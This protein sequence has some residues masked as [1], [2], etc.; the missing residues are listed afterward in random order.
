MAM[1]GLK[2][3]AV[4]GFGLCVLSKGAAHGSK[5]SC[6]A[7]TSADVL[8][9]YR[10]ALNC[11]NA[12]PTSCSC[13]GHKEP[14]VTCN[15]AHKALWSKNWTTTSDKCIKVTPDKDD[16]WAKHD[17]HYPSTYSTTCDQ[18][19]MEPGSWH[20]THIVNQTHKFQV[21][22]GYN[23]AWNTEAWCLAKFCWVDP[24]KCNKMDMKKSTWLNSYYSYSQCGA[25][26]TY[27]PAS[28]D[29]TTMKLCIAKAQCKWA[30]ASTTAASTTAA[31][32]NKTGT[33]G[34]SKG[35]NVMGVA[36]LVALTL[37]G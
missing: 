8:A 35:Q 31:S 28:C 19:G 22:A 33:T 2:I 13:S 25:K 7:K 4:L 14:N 26:D 29:A 16:P 1:V 11:T 9:D 5:S 6:Q 21:G 27:T 36:T 34:A 30:N 23:S 37:M 17:F 18:S 15:S 32:T 3:A 20:C 24:C 12:A 10:K